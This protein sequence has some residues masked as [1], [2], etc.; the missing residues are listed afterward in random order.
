[1]YRHCLAIFAFLSKDECSAVLPSFCIGIN[2]RQRDETM[3]KTNNKT[4]LTAQAC[5]H[6]K[7]KRLTSG[8]AKLGIPGKLGGEGDDGG[9]SELRIILFFLTAV[10]VFFEVSSWNVSLEN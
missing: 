9:V 2:A 6:G 8:T 10:G 7:K 5:Q 1:M 3:T 4:I